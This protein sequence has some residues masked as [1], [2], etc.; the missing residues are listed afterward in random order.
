MATQRN[1]AHAAVAAKYFSA[2]ERKMLTS[3]G[4]TLIGITTIAAEGDEFG[5]ANGATGIVMNDNGTQRIKTLLD[6]T[7]MLKSAAA[8]KAAPKQVTERRYYDESRFA[9]D[10][11]I[12]SV[13]IRD[14]DVCDEQGRSTVVWIGA[15]VAEAEAWI[16]EQI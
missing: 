7:A 1:T 8:V 16:K 13:T 12:D 10:I 5:F 3:M 4:I 11:A 2:A 14:A 15:T 6:V 9:M